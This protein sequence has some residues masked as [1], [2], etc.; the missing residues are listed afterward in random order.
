ML[1][2]LSRNQ[3]PSGA[4]VA[5]KNTSMSEPRWELL[6]HGADIGVCGIGRTKAEAF[7]YAATALTAVV[8][9][10]GS[11]RGNRAVQISCIAPDD[12]LLLVEWLNALIYEMATNKML[13]GRF[14]VSIDDHKLTAT[15]WGEP[16]DIALHEPAVEVK[17]ATCTEL[18]VAHEAGEW[19]AQCVVDV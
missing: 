1:R 17:G 13:F 12:D 19:R 8:T 10:P 2:F 3:F 15:A 5:F 16:V 11:V 18:K 6:P 14:D 4:T 7:A 9:E